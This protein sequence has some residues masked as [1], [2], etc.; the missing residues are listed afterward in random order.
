ML[1]YSLLWY[2]IGVISCAILHFTWQIISYLDGTDKAFYYIIKTKTIFTYFFFGT[3]GA[4]VLLPTLMIVLIS[5]VHYLV[6]RFVR[7]ESSE[8][9]NKIWLDLNKK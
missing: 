8:F 2:G 5:I 6:D 9:W 4:F 7:L 3:L 1:I